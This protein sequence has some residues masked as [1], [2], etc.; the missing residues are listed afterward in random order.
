MP[1]QEI[2]YE[3]TIMYKIVCK[4]LN[5]K[6]VY[7][8]HTTDF[9]KRKNN[10]KASCINEHNKKHNEYKYKF[11]RDNGG[12][13]NWEMI[14]IEK[15][16]CNDGNEAKNRERFWYESFHSL[17]NTYCPVRT[18]QEL[19]NANKERSKEYL[20]LNKEIIYEKRKEIIECDC[21]ITYTRHC[22]SR[23]MKTKRHQKFINVN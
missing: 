12:W 7:V 1:K 20:T 14:E 8:G 23:H 2:N 21:G 4:D 19:K 22:K 3:N 10:H 11:I 13:D 5:I 17:I 15:F 6:D 9:R 16:P 18:I